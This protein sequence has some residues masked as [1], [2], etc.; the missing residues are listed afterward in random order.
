M[1]SG[2]SRAGG[3]GGGAGQTLPTTNDIAPP[4]DLSRVT[5]WDISKREASRA[6][7]AIGGDSRVGFVGSQTL[8]GERVSDNSRVPRVAF[9]DIRQ[10][11]HP[12]AGTRARAVMRRLNEAGYNTA[13]RPRGGEPLRIRPGVRTPVIYIR[14]AR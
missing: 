5:T 6:M 3:G 8:S 4:A 2:K 14:R 10:P 13:Y 11:Y 7:D 12:E 9:V 1:A